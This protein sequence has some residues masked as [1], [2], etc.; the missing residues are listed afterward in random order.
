MM[1]EHAQAATE[2]PLELSASYAHR[3]GEDLHVVLTL[4][5]SNWPDGSTGPS[6]MAAPAHLELRAGKKVVRV[7]V[8]SRDGALDANVP[9]AGLRPGLWRLALAA[10]D[11]RA[12][13]V[14]AR[15]LNSRKQP[16]ALLPGPV[17]STQLA[18]PQ[19]SA[20][21]VTSARARAYRTA[22]VVAN[23][24]LGLL[25]EQQASRY[26]AVLKKAGRRVLG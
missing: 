11:G 13:P 9:S 20:P 4:A 10:A 15:L 26:R 14:Q 25:P 22:A 7:P 12:Q 24:G 8:T 18:P 1:S 3:V 21:P 6:G 2:L 23:K 5:D 19:P 16:V 17:P